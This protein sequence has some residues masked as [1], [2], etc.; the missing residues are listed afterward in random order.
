MIELAREMYQFD[1]NGYVLSEKCLLFLRS[2]FEKC[3]Q[4]Q[5][6]HEVVITLYGRLYY[7]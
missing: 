7:P 6:S 3:R 2:Y 1:E 5:N 4:E